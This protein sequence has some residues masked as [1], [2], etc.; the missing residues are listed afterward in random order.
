MTSTSRTYFEDMYKGD[1]DPWGFASRGYERR[2]YDL[3]I[4]SLPLAHYGSVYEPG[5]SIGVLTEKLAHRCDRLLGSDIIPAALRQAATR[6]KQLPH[7][8]VE[9]RPIPE[10]WPEG[11][12]DLIV[13]SEIAYYFSPNELEQITSL[14]LKSTVTGA[15]VVGVHWRGQTDYPLSGDQAHAIIEAT[16]GLRRMVHHVEPEFVLTVWERSE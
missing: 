10:A 6:T 11:Q 15:H 3:T 7:V 14:V 2:K 5:C 9:Y 1:P 16:L 4:A 8:R 12:F 13:L